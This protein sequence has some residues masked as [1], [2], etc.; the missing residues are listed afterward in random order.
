MNG[1]VSNSQ[2]RFNWL[3]EWVILACLLLLLGVLLFPHL[4]S[5]HDAKGRLTY[6]LQS[7]GVI[8][9]QAEHSS[10]L[11]APNTMIFPASCNR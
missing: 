4:G 3:G 7:V 9:T 8:D 11:R 6:L 10:G 2:V 5:Y 1:D